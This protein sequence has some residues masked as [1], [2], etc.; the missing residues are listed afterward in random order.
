[1][2]DSSSVELWTLTIQEHICL[3]G[4][5]QPHLH[6]LF[7]T[8]YHTPLAGTAGGCSVFFFF[9]IFIGCTADTLVTLVTVSPKLE[10]KKEP[11]KRRAVKENQHRKSILYVKCTSLILTYQHI[12]QV[13]I[14]QIHLHLHH[15]V[16]RYHF[17]LWPMTKD[18]IVETVQDVGGAQT[19]WCPSA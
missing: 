10:K 14:L 4:T 6:G 11:N 7:L 5:I 12:F 18:H 16:Q 3:Y 1:M 13:M 17:S 2:R 15:W 9:L 8:G 19:F